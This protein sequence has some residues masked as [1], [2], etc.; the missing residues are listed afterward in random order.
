MEEEQDGDEGDDDADGIEW[1]GAVVR[2]E[3]R[4]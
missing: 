3:T 2:A 4:K 1:F